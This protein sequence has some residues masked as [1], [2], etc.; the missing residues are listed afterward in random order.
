MF[1]HRDF[2]EKTT[3]IN[4]QECWSCFFGIYVLLVR[5]RD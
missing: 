2:D 1:D 3:K 5:I 4:A